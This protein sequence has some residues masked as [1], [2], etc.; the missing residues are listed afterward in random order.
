[1]DKEVKLE[2]I[3]QVQSRIVNRIIVN[4]NMLDYLLN[5]EDG[6]KLHE[7][8]AINS[9]AE[10]SRDSAILSF[11]HLFHSTEDFNFH[12]TMKKIR[13]GIQSNEIESTMD[14][15]IEFEKELK[16]LKQ[17]YKSLNLENIRNQYIAH[18]DS[19]P[20]PYGYYFNDIIV[21]LKELTVSFFTRLTDQFDAMQYLYTNEHDLQFICSEYLKYASLRG[22][23]NKDLKNILSKEDYYTVYNFLKKYI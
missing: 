22:L 9:L 18:I 3:F 19:K 14:D 20:A 15:Y 17:K 2:E 8:S 23:I 11:Y 12:I 21:D 16:V 5:S 1:M 13:E 7:D 4:C 10:I 6:K